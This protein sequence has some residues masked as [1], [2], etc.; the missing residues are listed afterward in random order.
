MLYIE[1]CPLPNLHVK[2][3]TSERGCI[4]RSDL[5]RDNSTKRRPLRDAL[6][7]S[8]WCP[9]RRKLQHTRMCAHREKTRWGHSEKEAI[10][11]PGRGPSPG[12]QSASTFTLALQPLEPGENNLCCLSPK[13]CGIF[14]GSLLPMHLLSAQFTSVMFLRTISA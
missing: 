2:A 5:Q 11:E 9:F 4:W 6:I 7:Q 14:Y 3:R 13:L 1:L 12:T 10:C 8:D